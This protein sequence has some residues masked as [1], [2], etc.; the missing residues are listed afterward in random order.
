ML[1]N[2]S[3]TDDEDAEE[4]SDEE[5]HREADITT[6]NREEL[7]QVIENLKQLLIK[8]SQE[9][10]DMEATIRKEV[11][12]DMMEIMQQQKT[13]FSETMED[14]RELLEEMYEGR[15]ENLKDSLTNYY[16]RELE[17]RDLRI[18]ELETALEEAANNT[19]ANPVDTSMSIKDSGPVRRS[20][21][22]ATNEPSDLNRLKQEI[23]D[24]KDEL[25]SKNEE[26][27]KLKSIHE[28]PS[29]AKTLTADVDRKIQ[30][31]Q[32]NIRLLR[33]EIQKFGTSLHQVDR[34]CCHTTGA[35]KLRQALSGCDD[36]LSK[37]EK[38]LAELQNN[39]VLV[40]MDLK[41]KATCIAEQYN[42][43][44]R[45]Q[46]TSSGLKHMCNNENIQ[47]NQSSKKPFLRNLLSR[48]PGTKALLENSP[49]SRVLRARRSPVLKT[50][51]FGTKY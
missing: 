15:L 24:L 25:R 31:G 10:L 50:I 11:C 33:T 3:Y 38:T 2:R 40:K 16:K 48:T 46:G 4:A 42:T 14:E 26:I 22:L 13:Q 6:F 19:T 43:V 32:K 44:Q 21:R 51:A 5:D 17:E 7:L 30:E 23:V 47:P 20:K 28:P 1:A 8:K 39:M 37:Q 41:K 27:G 35:E 12:N 18:Q 45:L 36:I 9:N 49:Y 34:A 29:S